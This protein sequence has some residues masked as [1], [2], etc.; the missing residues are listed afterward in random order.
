MGLDDAVLAG[1]HHHTLHD[2]TPVQQSTCHILPLLLE[3]NNM[4]PIIYE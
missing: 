3:G 1:L 2:T 4:V